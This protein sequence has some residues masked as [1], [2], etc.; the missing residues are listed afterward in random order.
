VQVAEDRYLYI[1]F[2]QARDL[3]R[4]DNYLRSAP[5][6]TMRSQVESY[7]N[8]LIQI[9]NP[10]KLKLIL[11]MIEWGALSDD[12]NIITVFMDGKKIIEQEGI[13]AVE[14]SSTGEI[15]RYELT[16]RLNTHVTLKVKIVEKNWLSS[17]DDNGQGSIVVRV[18]DLDALTLN[19][20]PPKNE[21]TNK[22]VFRLEGIPTSPH[23]PDWGE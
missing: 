11:A 7:K 9:Q 2:L 18:A 13:E 6:Q 17:Y 5:L 16:D 22:A 20:R 12:N 1:T 14:N 10:L 23:L 21:F 8:H 19:L 4:A 15:G 3:E